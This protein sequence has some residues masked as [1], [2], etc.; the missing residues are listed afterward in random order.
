MSE[1]EIQALCETFINR[2]FNEDDLYALRLFLRDLSKQKTKAPVTTSSAIPIEK[3]ETIVVAAETPLSPVVTRDAPIFP[4]IEGFVRAAATTSV[5]KTVAVEVGSVPKVS[6]RLGVWTSSSPPPSSPSPI[7]DRVKEA[8]AGPG[9]KDRL[10][11]WSQ[12]LELGE[13]PLVVPEQ[14]EERLAEVK[15]AVGVKDRLGTYTKVVTDRVTSVKTSTADP[16]LI[17]DRLGEEFSKAQIGVKDRLKTGWVAHPSD[18][19]VDPSVV[20]ER[21]AEV[22]GAAGVK[23]R[24]TILK[25]VAAETEKVATAPPEAVE[26]RLADVKGASGVKDRLVVLSSAVAEAEK[27]V[28]AHPEVV[29]ERLQGIERSTSIN[30][31]TQQWG[32]VGVEPPPGPRKQPIALPTEELTKEQQG[33]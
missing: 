13:R 28:V 17:E 15:G 14:V 31:R 18:V 4:K 33:L 29:R 26:E 21:L 27:I 16:T 19:Q 20:K 6:E 30:Q 10:G 25:E 9:V 5:E 32:T 23:D 12:A 11:N 3:K 8:L 22:K 7:Q 1:S 24:V 2:S